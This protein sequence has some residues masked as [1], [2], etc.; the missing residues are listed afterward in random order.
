MQGDSHSQG[1]GVQRAAQAAAQGQQGLT[2]LPVSVY[3]HWTVSLWLMTPCIPSTKSM[4]WL[5]AAGQRAGRVRTLPAPLTSPRQGHG[6]A[7]AREVARANS[8]ACPHK[9][10]LSSL[11]MR[12]ALAPIPTPE[13]VI[14][15]VLVGLGPHFD[16]ARQAIQVDKLWHQVLVLLRGEG[17]VSRQ[18]RAAGTGSQ[19]WR[20]PPAIPTTPPSPYLKELL[21]GEEG[22]P[23]LRALRV[24][25]LLWNEQRRSGTGDPQ[26]LV[27]NWGSQTLPAA[28]ESP[29]P[30]LNPCA[31]PQ[32]AA[33]ALGRQTRRV[34]AAAAPQLLISALPAPSFLL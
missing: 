4:I 12:G 28:R 16:Q 2:R 33:V 3:S 24:V 6:P 30:R 14:L 18:R 7:A 15:V 11:G 8:P 20:S 1:W 5:R 17:Q 10:Q 22:P 13:D 27:P 26:G 9:C 19:P 32:D 31:S 25:Q 21:E 29:S 23:Q 34:E